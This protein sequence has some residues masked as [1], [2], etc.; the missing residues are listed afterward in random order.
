MASS[1][2]RISLL[3]LCGFVLPGGAA[4]PVAGASAR[5]FDEVAVVGRKWRDLKR[6]LIETEDRFYERFNLLNTRDE[7]DIHCI[8]DKTT[9]TNVPQRLCR[10]SFLQKAE[11]VEA[12][13]FTEGLTLGTAPVG[14]HT[15]LATL[16]PLWQQRREEYRRTARALLE[17]DPELMALATKLGRLREQYQTG[18]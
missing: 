6:E 1:L 11:A 5:E 14:V 12:R 3:V 13:E 18:K 17:K 2:R 15:P 10:I 16:E 9:G 7:F 4:E 8:R